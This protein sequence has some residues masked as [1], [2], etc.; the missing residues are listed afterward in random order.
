MNEEMHEL[1]IGC[2]VRFRL[3][4]VLE[5]TTASL[6]R[7]QADPDRY[8]LHAPSQYEWSR[9][10]RL[11]ISNFEDPSKYSLGPISVMVGIRWI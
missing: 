4:V 11:C 5:K 6:S 3:E 9:R 7:K 8:S 10:N 2:R 1:G